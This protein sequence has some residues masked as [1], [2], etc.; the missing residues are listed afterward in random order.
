MEEF[1][2]AHNDTSVPE[3]QS[4][5]GNINR[6]RCSDFIRRIREGAF[7][8]SI[9]VSSDETLQFITVLAAAKNATNILE[10]G[11]AVGVSGICLLDACKNAHLTTIER[12]ENFYEEAGRNFAAAGQ[13]DRVTRL[14]GDAGEILPTLSGEFDFIFLDSAKAQY[15]KYLPTLKNLLPRGGVLVADDVLLYGYVNGEKPVPKK[16]RMLVEHVREYL[17]AAINDGD[18]LTSVV[19]V[20]DGIALSVKL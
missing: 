1:T 8:R 16:R 19:D 4:R 15:I 6:L 5:T 17:N 20:G 7:K 13:A 12:D 2:Y 3:R 18:L 10:I 11:T 9:P 14:S